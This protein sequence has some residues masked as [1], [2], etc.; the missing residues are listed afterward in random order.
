MSKSRE[1]LLVYWEQARAIYL[2]TVNRPVVMAGICVFCDKPI[3][4]A[5]IKRQESQS[6]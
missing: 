3:G 1:N 6:G 4:L 5:Q 2:Y